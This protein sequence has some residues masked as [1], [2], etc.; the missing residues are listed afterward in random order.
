M[1][2]TVMPFGPSSRARVFDQPTTPGR[3]V[4]ESA[5]LSIGSFTELDVMV[6][7]ATVP[8]AF[9]VR[10]A[11]RRQAHCGDQQQLDRGLDRLLVHLEGG[12]RGGPPELLTTMSMPPKASSVLSTSR[13]RSPGTRDVAANGERTQPLSLALEDVAPP[14]EHRDVRAFLGERFG[15]AEA[16]AGGRAADDRRPS[17]EREVHGCGG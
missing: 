6:T 15:D 13:S 11:E 9:E 16:D 17:F 4:F 12:V 7:I 8:G 3:T 10:E 1:Q 2:L 5:R 14:G